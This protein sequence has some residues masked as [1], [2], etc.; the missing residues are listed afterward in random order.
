VAIPTT[1]GV[2]VEP[3][4]TRADRKAFLTLPYRLYRGHPTWVPPLRMDEAFLGNRKKNPFFAHAEVAHFL[5][6][7]EGR[8]VG[9]IAAI[10]NRRHNECHGER[11][12]FFGRFDVE[13]DPEAARALVAAARAW[14]G[15]RGLGAMRGP[16]SYSSNESIGVLVDGFDRRP[17]V[18]MPYNRPDYDEL[19]RG[20]GLAKAKD[21]VAYWVRS[22]LPRPERVVRIARRTLDRQGYTVRL[23]DLKRW[24]AEIDTLLALYNRCWERNWGFV[25]MTEAEFRHAAKALKMIVDPR[26]FLFVEKPAGT[27]VGFV[28]AVP[29]VFEIIHDL[30]GRLFPLGLA[31]LLLRR[32]RITGARVMLLGVEPAYR[33]RGVDAALM[34]DVFVRAGQAG[35]RGGE[36]SWILEDNVRMRTDLES[37]G[38]TVTATYRVYEMPT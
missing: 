10:E 24:D 18:G 36:G 2:V 16:V 33:G 13:S 31:K 14:V 9:R 26:I 8:V 38:G 21:L 5:A 30:D 32:K 6:R 17:T 37:I 1:S 12:G 22:D 19:L 23:L 4:R 29:D 28:G 34:A 11:V 7:R 20:A 3:E 25:P 15:A 27:A 35:Y